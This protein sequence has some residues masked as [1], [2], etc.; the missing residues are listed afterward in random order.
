MNLYK[1]RFYST[2][3]AE[4]NKLLNAIFETSIHYSVYLPPVTWVSLIWIC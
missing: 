1:E 2:V 4:K 3:S